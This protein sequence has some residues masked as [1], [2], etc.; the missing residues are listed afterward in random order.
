MPEL[1]SI[2]QKIIAQKKLRLAQVRRE[3]TLDELKR[4]VQDT[5]V[6]K[7]FAAVLR[8]PGGSADS[9]ADPGTDSDA[10]A[11]MAADPG[12][13]P[14]V[15][16]IAEMKRRSP[17]RGLIRDPFNPTEIL[18]AYEAGGAAALSI[19]TEED[20]FEGSL[21]ILQ[22]VRAKTV[23]PILRKDFIIDPYQIYESRAAGADAVLLI[24]AVLDGPELQE[25]N[26]L[27]YD[28]GLSTLLE[29]HNS[30][31]LEQVLACRQGIVGINNRD[32]H[33]FE[34][35]LETTLALRPHIPADRLVVSESGIHQPQDIRLL[36]EAGVRAF[37]I[38]EH[39]MR[40]DDITAAVKKLKRAV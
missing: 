22:E 15:A 29:I 27:A 12:A 5:P 25:L 40:A 32:L 20:F 26:D 36:V 24:A 16:I 33:S 11:T 2:L 1:A 38:G 3:Q 6:P 37:L 8:S 21:A 13:G 39:F 7:D 28:L 35:H 4:R 19:L 17:S 34:V 23:K 18:F 31:E 9:A 14:K 10:R 30:R